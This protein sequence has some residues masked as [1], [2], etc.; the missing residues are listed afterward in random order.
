M[1][2]ENDIENITAI[3]TS[4]IA[5]AAIV[6]AIWQAITTRTHNKLTVVPHLVFERY[7]DEIS[8]TAKIILKNVG[9]GPAIIKSFDVYLDEI[10]QKPFNAKQWTDIVQIS[11][12]EAKSIAGTILEIDS[13]IGI[14]EEKTIL[15][16]EL[17]KTQ[18]KSEI[19]KAIY[20]INIK[21]N[22]ECVYGKQRRIELNSDLLD[23]P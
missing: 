19:N 2:F 13:A 3:S 14:N 21:I 4:I 17:S 9:T 8:M 10:K 15:N 11:N 1:C 22:Y 6:V 7:V 20:H 16:I 5:V 23:T 18:K 12:F